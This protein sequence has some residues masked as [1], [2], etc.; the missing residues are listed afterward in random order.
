MYTEKTAREQTEAA[1]RETAE[2]KAATAARMA[3]PFPERF[4]L[5]WDD[6]ELAAQLL[7]LRMSLCWLVQAIDTHCDALKH[8]NAGQPRR[9]T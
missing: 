4:G 5:N 2:L 3:V 7:K 1:E 6:D 8:P 9:R